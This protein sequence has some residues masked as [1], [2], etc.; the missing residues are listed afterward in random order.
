M[1]GKW[2]SD[3]MMV[4]YGEK[5]LLVHCFG[6]IPKEILPQLSNVLFTSISC[7]SLISYFIFR[8]QK[9]FCRIQIFS[10][11]SIN[12]H[13]MSFVNKALKR[14]LVVKQ[15]LGGYSALQGYC[16]HIIYYVARDLIT[17]ISCCVNKCK[18][19]NLFCQ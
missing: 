7:Y 4:K 18:Q 19:K 13:Q 9:C 16:P 17:F 6:C 14:A 8:R 1:E 15:L 12:L 3:F 2:K 11:L 10:C 5:F